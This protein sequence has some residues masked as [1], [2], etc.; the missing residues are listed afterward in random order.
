MPIRK[1]KEYVDIKKIFKST[2]EANSFDWR[3]I[4]LVNKCLTL[5]KFGFNTDDK[6]LLLFFNFFLY[7][8]KSSK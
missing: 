3:F 8:S 7:F 6:G 2:E 4:L 5:L 1:I